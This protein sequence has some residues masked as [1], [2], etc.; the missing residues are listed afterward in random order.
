MQLTIKQL[1]AATNA[2]RSKLFSNA[3]KVSVS[4]GKVKEGQDAHGY[5][6]SIPI[7]ALTKA[8][9]KKQK[10]LEIRIYFPK[11]RSK[12][13]QYVPPSLRKNKASYVGPEQAPALTTENKVWVRCNC[14]YFMYHCEVADAETDNATIH[15]SNGK[16]PVKT[17]PQGIPHLCKHLISAL[18]KGALLKK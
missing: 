4:F 9:N 6:R 14:E 7:R 18:R 2:H 5:Y 1:L 12:T 11:T 16:F 3:G 13:D 8:A 10:T 15:Y 17:N